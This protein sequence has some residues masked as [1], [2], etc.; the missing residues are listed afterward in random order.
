MDVSRGRFQSIVV[1]VGVATAVILL[2]VSTGIAV[3]ADVAGDTDSSAAGGPTV[4]D[5]T[6]AQIDH[7]DD[8][9]TVRHENPD[10]YEG[11]SDPGDLRGWLGDQL[12][13]R[14]Q[15][16]TVALSEGQS[17][18]AREHVDDEYRELA[19]QYATVSS[20]AG[21]ADD[22]DSF[23]ELGEEQDQLIDAVA[24][25]EAVRA[26]YDEA[27]ERGDDGTAREHARQLQELAEAIQER[28]ERVDE[29]Y[30]EIAERTDGDV[31]ESQELVAEFNQSVQADQEEV[32][33]QQFSETDL[34]LTIDD[35]TISYL[36]PLTAT[37]QLRTADGVPVD[38]EE[39]RLDVG[40]RTEYVETN[41]SGEFELT[42]RPRDL[43]LEADDL[44]VEFVPENQST[45]LGS[46]TTVDVSVEQVDPTI[47]VH[48]ATDEA[49]YGDEITVQGA[50]AVTDEPVDD[51]P[52]SVT[53]A[54]QPLGTVEASNGSFEGTF[55]LPRT[56]PAGDQEL[57]VAL[58]F[59]EQAL[60]QTTDNRSLTVGETASD[61][62]LDVSGENDELR[63]AG[64]LVDENGDGLE[65]ESLEIALENTSIGSTTTGSDGAFNATVAPPSDL[66]GTVLLTVRYDTP[67]TN[68]ASAEAEATTELTVDTPSEGVGTN[69]P[70]W[71]WIGLGMLGALIVV[72]AGWWS[73]RS[74]QRQVPGEGSIST[75][76]RTPVSEAENRTATPSEYLLQAHQQLDSDDPDS[77]VQ[78]G[79]VAVRR[80]FEPEVGSD[81]VTPREFID[82]I[83]R[84][85][86]ER[87]G[88]PEER[89]LRE[90][91][92]GYE[93]A[94]FDEASLSRRGAESLLECASDLCA[95][96]DG[97]E[98][99]SGD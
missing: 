58:E 53:L 82:R 78:Y 99:V 49:A 80:A 51:V 47:T 37:G 85:Q 45:Y 28:S 50:I 7:D 42:H 69:V 18:L 89:L 84:R 12:A 65:N 26:E 73:R 36:E 83:R 94:V 13:D 30:D 91:T 21:D 2:S 92:R 88:E 52:L 11:A 77:A 81:S 76:S 55:D 23:E 20:E 66:E 35:E 9:E 8:N 96:G 75:D 72:G 54:G 41:D 15:G 74:G 32:S 86:P 22:G 90:L 44:T 24:E 34:E 46:E 93:R 29:R 27:R 6:P 71:A 14:L 4:T 43:S 40:G 87:L 98:P 60:A 1:L 19:S 64:H 67:G 48:T 10:E 57:G 5:S 16:S 17:E 63:L 56:V 62:L 95:V 70:T 79:Y 33:A 97:S 25:Y 68:I 59:E 61:L 39:L 31:S 3:S 38:S